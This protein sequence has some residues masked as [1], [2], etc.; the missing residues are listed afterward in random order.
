[1]QEVDQSW[2]ITKGTSGSYQHNRKNNG[3]K[4]AGFDECF[5][6]NFQAEFINTGLDTPTGY[7]ETGSVSRD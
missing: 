2:G 3:L 6:K 7:R 5:L 1:V 4:E